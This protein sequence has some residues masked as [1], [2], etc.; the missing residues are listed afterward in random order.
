MPKNCI[1]LLQQDLLVLHHTLGIECKNKEA[2]L[3]AVKSVQGTSFEQ[4]SHDISYSFLV[5]GDG[6][7]YEGRG[8]GKEGGHTLCYNLES[9]GVAF[10]GDFNTKWPGDCMV[11]RFDKFLQVG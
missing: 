3:A 1:D 9:Y 5:G 10:I 7:I 6:R 2:C 4:G 11:K 8:W